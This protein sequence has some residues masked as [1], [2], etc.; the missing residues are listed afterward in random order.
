MKKLGEGSTP[1]PWYHDG[2]GWIRPLLIEARGVLQSI[3]DW[4]D[5][6]V[7]RPEAKELMIRNAARTLL[8]KL[9]GG[10]L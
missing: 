8:T 2:E 6:P 10:Q 5:C 3:L 4:Q 9:E 1:R 7:T